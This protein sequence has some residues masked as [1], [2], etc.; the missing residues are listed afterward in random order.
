LVSKKFLLEKFD[1][2]KILTKS[3]Q[4]KIIIT[5]RGKG[6]GLLSNRRGNLIPE[7]YSF[8]KNLG[9]VENQFFF[10]EVYVS[11]AEL[12]VVLYM[13]KDGNVVRKQ[14]IPNAEYDKVLCEE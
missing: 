11:Q 1:D 9:T 6:F 8:I 12:H 7:D 3:A 10:V 4:E 14:T 2:Y 13:D 5:Y